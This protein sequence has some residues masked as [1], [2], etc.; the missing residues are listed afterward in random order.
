M[1]HFEKKMKHIQSEGSI[2]WWQNQNVGYIVLNNPKARNA[3]SIKMMLDLKDCVHFFEEHQ[4]SII[5][6]RSK[7]QKHFCAGGDLKDVRSVLIQEDHGT[8]MC[9]WMTH[10]LNRLQALPAFIVV[11]VDGA[12]IGGG[13]E[14]TTI[15]D[16]IIASDNSKIA[17]VQ[18]ALGV[19]TGWGGGE[20]LR[21]KLGSQKAL[22]ILF[23]AK[24]YSASEALEVG[25][26]DEIGDVDEL[27]EDLIQ[28]VEDS[29]TH[30]FLLRWLKGEMSEKEAFTHTWGH[31]QHRDAL[32]L[33]ANSKT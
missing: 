9:E 7:D 10:Y 2:E 29:N 6:I 26:F 32:G 17:F 3:F 22:Q 33:Q 31:S 30:H 25:L 21:C 4:V 13:A 12:A 24:M 28:M 19:T 27:L 16:W 1:M 14:L 18:S 23:R 15:G 5:I 8:L 20:R 11:A